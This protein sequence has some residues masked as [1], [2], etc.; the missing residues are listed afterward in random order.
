MIIQPFVENGL[1]HG[2]IHKKGDKKLSIS[3][4]QVKG[5]LKCL[6]TDNGVG[7][8]HSAEMKTNSQVKKHSMGMKITEERLQLLQ[9]EASISINDLKDDSGIACG[10]EVTIIIPLAF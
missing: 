5:N 3:F 10:T 9:T 6:I 2:L 4:E 1:W 7:R 8:D